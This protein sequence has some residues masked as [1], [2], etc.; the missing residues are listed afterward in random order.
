MAQTPT[1]RASPSPRHNS[2]ISQFPPTSLETSTFSAHVSQWAPVGICGDEPDSS[3][4]STLHPTYALLSAPTPLSNEGS[5]FFHKIPDHQLSST[6]G[7]NGNASYFS[8]MD[9]GGSE[10]YSPQPSSSSPAFNQLPPLADNSRQLTDLDSSNKAT[11]P[12]STGGVSLPGFTSPESAFYQYQ[13]R[14]EG[15]L[16]QICGEL[17]AGFHHGAYVCE[18]CKVGTLFLSG[19][20]LNLS[21]IL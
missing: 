20:S 8:A 21:F 5:Q 3:S 2:G 7:T 11:Q 6:G 13:N 17:A 9:I 10:Y 4:T 16:C 12:R 15:Q 14:M 1:A 19:V 18:A